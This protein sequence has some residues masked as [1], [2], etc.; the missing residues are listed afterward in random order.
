L[1]D[2]LLSDIGVEIGTLDKAKEELVDDLQMGPSKFE[3]RLVL[4]WIKSVTSRVDLRRDRSEQVGRKLVHQ[5]TFSSFQEGTYHIDDLWVNLL[6]DHTSILRNVF[7]H[8][9]QSLRLDL[10]SLKLGTGVV[11]IKYDFTLL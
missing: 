8:F 2:I 4:L 11:E 9:M 5:L 7:Q 3:N 1:I 6:R 10:L